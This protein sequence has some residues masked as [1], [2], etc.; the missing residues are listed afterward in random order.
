MSDKSKR[1]RPLIEVL[2][3]FPARLTELR[4]AAGLTRNGLAVKAGIPASEVGRYEAGEK[5]PT[6]RTAAKLVAALDCG[7]GAFDGCEWPSKSK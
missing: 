7:L 6:L 5:S 1:G 3:T 2:N 4:E